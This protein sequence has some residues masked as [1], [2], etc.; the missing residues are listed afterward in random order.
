MVGERVRLRLH[1]KPKHKKQEIMSK[2]VRVEFVNNK[3]HAIGL[4]YAKGEVVDLDAKLAKQVIEDGFAVG[5]EL[6]SDL[7]EDF[8][9]R[10]ALLES[11]L[12]TIDDIK[13]ADDSLLNCLKG[14]GKKSIAEI[15]EFIELLEAPEE[16]E[17][18][19][20]SEL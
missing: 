7:P 16:E 10:E 19:E 5:A 11:G 14:V 8:P 2:T 4:A 13:A 15:R 3:A 20:S 9:K 17:S 12:V 18:E 1:P 6:E